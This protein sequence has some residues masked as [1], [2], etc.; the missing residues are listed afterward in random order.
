LTRELLEPACR[1][2]DLAD[3]NQGLYEIGGGA[4]DARMRVPEASLHIFDFGEVLDGL[5]VSIA[6][7][8]DISEH[9]SRAQLIAAVSGAR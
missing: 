6:G 8:G 2:C 7:Q 5:T 3:S 1:L 4:H 9:R